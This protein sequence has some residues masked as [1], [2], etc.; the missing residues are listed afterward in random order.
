M[1]GAGGQVAVPGAVITIVCRDGSGRWTGRSIDKKHTT[2]RSACPSVHTPTRVERH[3]YHPTPLSLHHFRYDD[4]RRGHSGHSGRSR[5]RDT[6]GREA[7]K[8]KDRTLTDRF[9]AG[10]TS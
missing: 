3:N 10:Y 1:S 5:Q 8:T 9:F 6:S 4:Q 7:P 2:A